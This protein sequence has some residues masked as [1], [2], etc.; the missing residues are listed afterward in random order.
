M[1]H[2]K[3]FLV[4]SELLRLLVNILTT[5]YEYSHSNKENLSLPIQG[6]LSEKLKT[7]S[8]FFIVFFEYT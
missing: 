2:E 4:K 5:Y 6:Q 8:P 3:S 1:S 7:I